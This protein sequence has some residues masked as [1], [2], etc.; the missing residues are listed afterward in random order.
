MHIKKLT[1]VDFDVMI[2]PLH[3]ETLMCSPERCTNVECGKFSVSND[4]TARNDVF[5]C[6]VHLALQEHSL[7]GSCVMALWEI[8]QKKVHLNLT[9]ASK[10]PNEQDTY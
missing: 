8:E 10:L 6:R 9:E 5:L 1:N 4:L 2:I 3:D 7:A